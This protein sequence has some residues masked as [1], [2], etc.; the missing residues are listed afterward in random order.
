VLGL[1]GVLAVFF[2]RV[3]VGPRLPQPESPP[4]LPAQPDTVEAKRRETP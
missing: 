4:P 3:S 2:H 1:L